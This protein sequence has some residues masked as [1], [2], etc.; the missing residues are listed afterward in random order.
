MYL[1]DG[2]G[3]DPDEQLCQHIV[4]EVNTGYGYYKIPEDRVEKSMG[5]KNVNMM[6]C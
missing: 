1:D 5:I 4:N 2:I 6:I 3:I